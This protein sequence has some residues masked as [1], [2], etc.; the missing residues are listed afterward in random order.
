MS[1]VGGFVGSSRSAS[2]LVAAGLV[3]AAAAPATTPPPRHESPSVETQ[4]SATAF[5]S[6]QGDRIFAGSVAHTDRERVEGDSSSRETLAVPAPFP[7]AEPA[8][9]TAP[10][11]ALG[12]SSPSEPSRPNSA[13]APIA[14]VSATCPATWFCFPRV[15]VAGPIV[16]YA[17]CSGS[18]EVGSAIRSFTC[19]SNKYLVGHAYTP[20]G[21]IRQWVVGDVVYAYGVRYSVSGAITQSACSAPVSPLAPLSLQTSLGSGPC[22]AV[23]VVQA[24]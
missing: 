4:A 23:L 3:L 14:P 15:G 10:R 8:E 18:T 24:R 22:G 20:F 19:L 11:P 21:L 16:P 12:V 17:D 7:V 1:I 5:R 9:R 2:F 13:A 6:I